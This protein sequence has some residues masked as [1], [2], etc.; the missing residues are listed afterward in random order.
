N[1]LYKNYRVLVYFDGE[2]TPR[3]NIPLSTLFSG[4]QPPFLK[5][6]V[7][8]ALDSSGGHYSYVPMSFSES[9]RVEL[10]GAPSYYD[11]GYEKNDASL[12]TTF[13]PSADVS[14]IVS[15]WQRAGQDP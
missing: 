10:T 12:A 1:G 9:A 2:T 7:G 3:V 4:T 11:I 13:D 14:D 5:P 15:L 6:L 8:D